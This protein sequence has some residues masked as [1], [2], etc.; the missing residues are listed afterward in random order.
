MQGSNTDEF[1]QEE[2]GAVNFSSIELRRDF[3]L[4][5][6]TLFHHKNYS[7]KNSTCQAIAPSVYRHSK[8]FRNQAGRIQDS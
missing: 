8:A 7:Q 5:V 3:N 4:Y 1:A 6:G 2:L